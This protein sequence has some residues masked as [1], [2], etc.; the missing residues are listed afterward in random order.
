[1]DD[2][3]RRQCA[4]WIERRQRYCTSVVVQGGDTYC[5]QHTPEALAAARARS[6]ASAAAE[7]AGDR[8]ERKYRRLESQ[9]LASRV[10]TSADIGPVTLPSWAAYA[11]VH[12][13][14]GCARGR[15]LLDL[16]TQRCAAKR[17]DGHA[18]IGAVDC[19]LAAPHLANHVGVEIRQDL[20]EEANAAV[21]SQ[22]LGECV[23]FVAADMARD[24]LRRQELFR[25]V[26]GGLRVVSI[27]FPDPYPPKWRGERG[28][29]LT[30]GLVV[31]MHAALP[32]GG[33]V[34]VA[35]DKENVAIDMCALLESVVRGADGT[36]SCMEP[37]TS[38]AV[39]DHRCFDRVCGDAAAQNALVAA[40]RQP[41]SPTS[42][43]LGLAQCSAADNT[44]ADASPWL[45]RNIWGKPTEREVSCERQDA[46]G[47][48]R[49]V[50]RALFVRR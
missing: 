33:V 20:V 31:D 24:S 42:T 32:P 14:I 44:P 1:M 49:T 38:D 27:C 12:L 34:Y 35:S 29:T 9:H 21:A 8:R 43:T 23:S 30:F 26:G 7:N 10:L 47:E 39:H 16:G 5:S 22:G 11:P 50:R 28:R 37:D 17:G 4:H 3:G 19:D 15:W 6:A 18:G 2:G 40:L 41:V 13:D 48:W 25:A 46:K 36:L 45:K